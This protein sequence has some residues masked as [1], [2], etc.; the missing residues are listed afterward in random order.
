MLITFSGCT[1][2]YYDQVNHYAPISAEINGV[3]YS[4]DYELQYGGDG[5]PVANFSVLRDQYHFHSGVRYIMS[6]D[7][8]TAI[9]AIASTMDTLGFKVN[10]KYGIRASLNIDMETGGSHFYESTN[11]WIEF[12]KLEARIEGRFACKIHNPEDNSI[13]YEVKNG[14]FDIPKVLSSNEKM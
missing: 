11:G 9:I 4:D 14:K 10:K 7:G 5:Y 2:E 13:L 3:L 12:T 8:N 6:D 1:P